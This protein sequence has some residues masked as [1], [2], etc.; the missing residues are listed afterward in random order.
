MT[1][2]YN[3]AVGTA[4][5]G[6]LVWLVSILAGCPGDSASEACETDDCTGGETD[7]T[8]GTTTA[9]TSSPSTSGGPTSSSAA[10]T[11]TPTSTTATSDDD[12]TGTPSEDWWDCAWSNRTRLAVLGPAGDEVL[13]NF[14]VPLVPNDAWF[15][16]DVAADDGVDLRFVDADGNV[17]PHEIESW[18][19]DPGY[20][21]WFQVPS[22]PSAGQGVTIDLYYGNGDAE[23][24]E[25]PADVWSAYARVWHL[26]GAREDS[27]ASSSLDGQATAAAGILGNAELFG[28]MDDGLF[29]S[30]VGISGDL[31]A[32]GATLSAWVNPT[33][34]GGSGFGRVC[35]LTSGFN[36]EQGW[37]WILAENVSGIAFIRGHDGNAG[38]WNYPNSVPLDAWTHVTLSYDD[39]DAKTAP[40][41]YANGQLVTANV[42]GVPSGAVQSD[43]PE[44]LTI[45][46]VAFEGETRRFDGAIDELRI[47]AEV[48]SE[49]WLAAEHA[50]VLGTMVAALESSTVPADC[51]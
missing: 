15:D 3:H 5:W 30:P 6:G 37:T 41:A 18:S 31:F 46:E 8:A 24:V 23:D 10:T 49:R 20:V 40:V 44:P 43:A 14:A 12:D 11:D 34:Y 28:E 1:R 33:S 9:S 7:T 38:F 48:S 4:R 39:S 29:E 51:D 13:E 25:A 47:R 27:A 35:S 42:V 32:T 17:L 16:F 45:G 50:S 19:A 2:R 36:A 21:V 26:S 22:I